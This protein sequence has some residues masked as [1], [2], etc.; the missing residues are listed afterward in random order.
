MIDR[1]T[2][3]SA[4]IKARRALLVMEEQVAGFGSLNV[5]VHLKLE[6]EDK[7]QQITELTQRIEDIQKGHL[8]NPYRGLFAFR[9]NDAP[10]FFGRETFIEQLYQAVK[11]KPLVAVIGSSG[12]GKSSVV[13]A[14]LLPQLRQE[15]GWLITSFRPGE[16]PFQNLAAAL[17]P[18]LETELSE[19]ARLVETN[20]LATA[21]LQGD[22]T[23]G[24]II[25]RIVEKSQKE[26]QL[27]LVADQ[28]EELYTP[29]RDE[30]ERQ[31]FLDMLLSTLNSKTTPLK[32]VLTLRADFF[33]AAQQ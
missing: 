4:L 17:L 28:F 21:L 2:L 14:G 16:Q 26:L 18:L 5:P 24:Q 33:N 13:F 15:A 10:F 8:N 7:Q 31:K 11:Y 20:R 19:T 6:L 3:E 1:Q 12:S 29:T 30:T 23:L 22:V 9:E 27:L 25:K 32:L